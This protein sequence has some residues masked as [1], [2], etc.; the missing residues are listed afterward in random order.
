[1]K[2]MIASLAAFAAVI[3][4]SPVVK[5]ADV[6]TLTPNAAIALPEP[7]GGFDY[8]MAD[9]KYGRIYASHPGASNIAVANT[10]NNTG[11]VLAIDCAVNGLAID[12]KAGKVYFAG[13]GGHLITLDRKTLAKIGDIPLGGPADALNFD[14]TNRKLYVDQDGG[15]GA[16][17]IDVDAAKIVG[18]VPIEG[19]PEYI[20]YNRKTDK[21]YQNIKPFNHL[22]VIDPHKNKVI[23]T[24]ATAP[25]TSPHGLA[26]DVKRQRF[27]VGGGGKL[28]VIDIKTGAVLGSVD[29]GKCDQIDYD[30]S[31]KRIYADG[32]GFLAVISVASTTPK[33]MAKVAIAP[34]ARAVT[35]D[36]QTHNVWISYTENGKSYLQSFT[37]AKTDGE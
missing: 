32:A 26:L 10:K 16:W 37:P 31:T 4:G 7:A 33:V 25:V 14:P 28:A 3:L 12:E 30:P 5:A 9:A 11:S 35:V 6:V 36:P 21:M 34:S 19:D 2:I 27:Y 20:V 24:W 23:A 1:M 15:T 8:M 17:V 29:F 22:Q 13:K 18:V